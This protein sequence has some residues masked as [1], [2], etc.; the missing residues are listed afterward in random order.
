LLPS[1]KRCLVVKL[2]IDDVR[3]VAILVLRCQELFG[4]AF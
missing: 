1:L 4:A 2:L 3:E